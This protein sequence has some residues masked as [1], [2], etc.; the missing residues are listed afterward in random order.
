MESMAAVKPV[1]K[2]AAFVAMEITKQEIDGIEIDFVEISSLPMLNLI[3]RLM[4]SIRRLL[5]LSGRGFWPLIASSLLPQSTTTLLLFKTISHCKLK[6]CYL[7]ELGTFSCVRMQWT[8]LLDHQSWADKAA[9]IV[10]VAGSLGGARAQYHY[11]QIG[12]RL[13][14][15]FI[16]KEFFLNASV[17]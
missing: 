12:V 15:H 3:S 14:L 17:S 2:V 4:A 10:T 8:G 7:N 13:D 9:A 1:I 5:R 11:R 6:E 16:N